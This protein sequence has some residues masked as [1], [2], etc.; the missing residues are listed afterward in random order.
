MLDDPDV[1]GFVSLTAKNNLWQAANLGH[2]DELV[3][4][5]RYLGQRLGARRIGSNV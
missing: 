3:V 4:D 2:V 1:T 5:Q